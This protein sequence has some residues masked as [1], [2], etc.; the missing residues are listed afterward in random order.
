MGTKTHFFHTI[1]H[2][3]SQNRVKEIKKY[4]DIIVHVTAYLKIELS[5][6]LEPRNLQKYQH[7]Y[8]PK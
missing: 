3:L 4:F 6:D 8:N 5:K 1:T 2:I 7:K